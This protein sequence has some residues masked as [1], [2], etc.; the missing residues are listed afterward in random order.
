MERDFNYFI[1]GAIAIGC[2]MLKNW[3][4]MEVGCGPKRHVYVIDTDWIEKSNL[5]RQFLFQNT[6][7]DRF[8]S[9]TAAAAKVMNPA[10]NVT[11]F[12]GK[13]APDTENIFG[14]DFYDKL[15]GV[16][17]YVDQRCLFLPAPN[18]RVWY[19]W[20]KGQ[21]P[22]CRPALGGELWCYS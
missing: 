17:S 21:H 4:L 11:D 2:E 13:V 18:S 10:L 20:N 6:N 5:S 15:T 12:Q 8:K 1:V 3:A 22:S 16:C 19:T 7:I 14:D 9:S